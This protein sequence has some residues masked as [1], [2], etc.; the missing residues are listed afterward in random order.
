MM[1]RTSFACLVALAL[2]GPLPAVKADNLFDEQVHDFGTVPRGVQ[3]TH[4]FRLT[5]AGDRPVR[6][7]GLRVSCGCT[8]ATMP[9]SEVA[10]GHAGAL[11]AQMDTRRFEGTKTVTIFVTLD[12]GSG[13]EEARL[14]VSALSREDFNMSPDGV[15]FGP[16][17]RGASPAVVV[18]VAQVGS[19]G[20]LITG[21]S[22]ESNYVQATAKATRRATGE[23]AYELT[24]RLRPDIPA[25][26]WY[27]DIWLHTDRQDVGRIR[28]PVSVEVTPAVT[29]NPGG[30]ELGTAAK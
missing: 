9:Q 24:A 30:A 19:P 25:G 6:V 15:A 16:V 1:F 18:T 26:R 13:L 29:V 17:A 7:T 21:V 10:P 2:A 27:T 28:V 11:L 5:N 20:W 8:T 22:C 14:A 4:T 12:R 3:L 23:I